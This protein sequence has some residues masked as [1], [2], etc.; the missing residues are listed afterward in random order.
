MTTLTIVLLVIIAV[1]AAALL[2]F[3][4]GAHS[5]ANGL[6]KILTGTFKR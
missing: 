4:V 1:M 2:A 3:I 5:L 6:G